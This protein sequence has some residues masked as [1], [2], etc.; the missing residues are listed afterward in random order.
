MQSDW[1]ILT[2]LPT[3]RRFP[4]LLS[5][6]KI[7]MACAD[8]GRDFEKGE[9]CFI[10]NDCRRDFPNIYLSVKEGER[11]LPSKSNS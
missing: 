5:I 10:L 4:H 9:F 7:I 8:Y 11:N 6:R 2:V 3:L 1:L